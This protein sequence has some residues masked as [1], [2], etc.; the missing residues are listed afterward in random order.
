MVT[1]HRLVVR[2]IR[3]SL[4]DPG[5]LVRIAEMLPQ[6]MRRPAKLATR[7][8]C[9]ASPQIIQLW[10]APCSPAVSFQSAHNRIGMPAGRRIIQRLLAR[11]QFN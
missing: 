4:A 5:A 10:M 6:T 11:Q 7:W 2:V 1:A 3:E 8:L 9:L